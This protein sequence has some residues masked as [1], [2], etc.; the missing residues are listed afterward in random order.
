MAKL[1]ENANGPVLTPQKHVRSELRS[2][3]KKNHGKFV[4]LPGDAESI[5]MN[6]LMEKV[7]YNRMNESFYRARSPNKSLDS[8]RVPSTELKQCL[9]SKGFIVEGDRALY[10]K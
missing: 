5:V 3:E 2:T 9:R 1:E 6:A 10:R 4:K 8:K 7:R